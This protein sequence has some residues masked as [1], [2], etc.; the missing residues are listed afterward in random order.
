[1]EGQWEVA[2]SEISH[3]PVYQNVTERKFMFFDR[4]VSKSSDFYYLDPGVLPSITDIVEAMNTLIHERH[5]HSEKLY[6]SQIVSKNAK[7]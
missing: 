3:P 2:N 6:H 5:N 1:M 7:K 4:K